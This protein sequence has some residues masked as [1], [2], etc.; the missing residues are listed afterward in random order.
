MRQVLGWVL[1]MY[2][3]SPSLAGAVREFSTFP[4]CYP[5]SMQGEHVGKRDVRRKEDAPTL[6]GQPI[7]QNP[8]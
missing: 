4:L 2:Y 1:A 6:D 5:R 3:V 7:L 8:E